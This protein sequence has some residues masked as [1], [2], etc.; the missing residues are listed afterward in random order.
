MLR[1]VEKRLLTPRNHESSRKLDVNARLG[2]LGKRLR[3][4][5]NVGQDSGQQ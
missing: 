3:E 5:K 4:K 1:E 2:N